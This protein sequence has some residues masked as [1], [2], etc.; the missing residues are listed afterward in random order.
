[1]TDSELLITQSVVHNAVMPLRA[2]LST[3]RNLVECCA[4]GDASLYTT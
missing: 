4:T 1:M 2:T 3:A